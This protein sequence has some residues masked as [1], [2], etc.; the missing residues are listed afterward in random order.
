VFFSWY[1]NFNEV[2]IVSSE[3]LAGL[4][5]G[6]LVNF[7]PGS[8]VKIQT[9]PKVYVAAKGGVL[10]WL[11]GDELPV[12]FFGAGWASQVNDI[13]DSFFINYKIG[14]ALENWTTFNPQLEKFGVVS[15]DQDMGL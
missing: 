8:L 3:V 5:L 10:R 15:I 2:K 14:D 7:R 1:D 6:G 12:K 13:S 4:P 9:D 11:K